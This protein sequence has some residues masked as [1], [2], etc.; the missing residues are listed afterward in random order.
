M[1]RIGIGLALATLGLATVLRA[2]PNPT[3]TRLL[4]QPAVSKDKIAFVYAEDLWVADLD[5]KN[6]RRL[7]SDLGA[8]GYPAFSPMGNGSPLPPPMRATPTYTLFR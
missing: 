8:E 5:G 2:E 7:T 6:P 4:T 3:D 1:H